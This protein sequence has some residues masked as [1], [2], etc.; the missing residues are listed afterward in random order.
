MPFTAATSGSTSEVMNPQAKKSVVTAAKASVVC[1]ERADD[2]ISLPAEF[3]RPRFRQ[4][5]DR[6]LVRQRCHCQGAASMGVNS[7]LASGNRFGI[8]ASSD[9]GR[10]AQGRPR[11]RF[12][13]D[14]TVLGQEGPPGCLDYGAGRGSR[15]G[16]G[17]ANG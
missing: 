15:A 14:E 8:L 2:K 7:A 6:S 9:S 1:V 10:P 12:A 11:R 3:A 17:A 16:G 13:S 5:F 4:A